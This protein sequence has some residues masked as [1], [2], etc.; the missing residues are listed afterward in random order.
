MQS[1]SHQFH[2]FPFRRLIPKETRK[3]LRSPSF[4]TGVLVLFL[5]LIVFIS[6]LLLASWWESL[7]L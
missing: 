5:G 3:F 2:V 6:V 1:H 4:A 7:A